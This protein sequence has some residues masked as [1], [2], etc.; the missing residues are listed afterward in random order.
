MNAIA[1]RPAAL[2]ARGKPSKLLGQS[3]LSV[4]YR[5]EANS[6]MA[7]VKPRPPVTP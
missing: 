1:S 7:T 3:D 4:R 2:S 5:M 6:T